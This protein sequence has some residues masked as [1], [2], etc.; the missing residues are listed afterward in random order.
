MSD[1]LPENPI[2]GVLKVVK[3]VTGEELIGVV[4]DTSVDILSIRLP[5][6]LQNYATKSPTGDIIEFVKL[7]NYLYNVKDFQMF[8][9]RNA[10]VY[11]AVPTDDLRKMYETYI[12]VIQENPKSALSYNDY[13]VS[14]TPE[15]ALQLMNDLFNNEDFVNFVNDLIDSFEGESIEEEEQEEDEET[16]AESFIEA[17]EVQKEEEQPKKKK[18]KRV[19]PETNKMPYNPDSPPENPESWSDNPTDY[20]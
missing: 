12:T 14:E 1:S 6:I 11:T 15:N 20:I 13:D 3:L 5:A 4:N 9:N 19:K 8:V 10:I 17:E 18:R 2:T 16:V 7:V